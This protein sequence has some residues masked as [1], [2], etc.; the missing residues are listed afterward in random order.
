MYYSAY[1][2]SALNCSVKQNSE[3][4]TFCQYQSFVLG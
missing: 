4:V 1:Q 2:H 3:N